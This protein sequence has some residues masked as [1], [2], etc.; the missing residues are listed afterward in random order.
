M[1]IRKASLDDYS[2]FVEM[3][4][5]IQ[6]LHSDAEPTF[7]KSKI[8]FSKENF[9]KFVTQPEFFM[10]LGFEDKTC[11][12]YLFSEKLLLP[13][14]PYTFACNM[15]YIRHLYVVPEMRGRGFAKQFL[16]LAKEIAREQQVANIELDSWSFNQEAIG[17]FKSVGFNTRKERLILRRD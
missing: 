1:I 8:Q 9:E 7:F 12:G 4:Q 15:L 6:K 10:N 11:V 3:N 17:L 5:A 13:E 2:L 16:S 14:S